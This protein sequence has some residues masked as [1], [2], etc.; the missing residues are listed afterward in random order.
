LPK[1][2]TAWF[3]VYFYEGQAPSTIAIKSKM[4]ARQETLLSD[5]LPKFCCLQHK[6]YEINNET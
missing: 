4:A 6:E 1:R 3:L 5:I 2:S